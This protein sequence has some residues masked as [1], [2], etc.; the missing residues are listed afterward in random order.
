MARC[1]KCGGSYK[2][3]KGG[4]SFPDLTRDGKVTY[5]DILKGRGAF[6]SGGSV[7]PKYTNNPNSIQ[8]RILMN[9][10][11]VNSYMSGGVMKGDKMMKG[12]EYRRGGVMKTK[13]K[14]S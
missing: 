9:G 2:Y 7:M 10:G 3:E 6:K 13:K 14:N 4:S 1:M 11:M 5:A 12:G 8:G